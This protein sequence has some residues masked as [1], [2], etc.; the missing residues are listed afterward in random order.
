[1]AGEDGAWQFRW[2]EPIRGR[3]TLAGLQQPFT[4]DAHFTPRPN[5][6]L[7]WYNELSIP[8]MVRR[9]LGAALQR[10]TTE[11]HRYLPTPAVTATFSAVEVNTD[12][13]ALG[14]NVYEE[15]DSAASQ[16]GAKVTVYEVDVGDG[17]AASLRES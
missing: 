9:W 10:T 12:A 17:G 1:M 6:L 4:I 8:V 14:V 11:P 3:A 15:E 16:A 2:S 5:T 13:V 7:M